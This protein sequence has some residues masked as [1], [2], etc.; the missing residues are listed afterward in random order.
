MTRV[1]GLFVRPCLGTL[2]CCGRQYYKK[3][4]LLG[5]KDTGE[6]EVVPFLT[7]VRDGIGD[8]WG[9]YTIGRL[10]PRDKNRLRRFTDDHLHEHSFPTSSL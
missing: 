8:V 2:G 1:A 6:T 3:D 5:K 10:V 9:E 7:D 4:L